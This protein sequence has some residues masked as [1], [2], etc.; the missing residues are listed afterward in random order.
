M[1]ATAAATAGDTA[2]DI[3]TREARSAGA[4]HTKQDTIACHVQ[5]GVGSISQEYVLTLSHCLPVAACSYASPSGGYGAS[6]G[7]YGPERG[8]S[9]GPPRTDPYRR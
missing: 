4:Q 2:G 3:P 9:R 7:S 1:V 6:G 5:V 8:A